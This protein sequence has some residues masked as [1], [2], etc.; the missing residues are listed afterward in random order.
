MMMN[1]AVPRLESIEQRGFLI[2]PLLL[3]RSP[4]FL[5]VSVN[6]SGMR[7]GDSHYGAVSH[8]FAECLLQRELGKC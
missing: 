3:K 4:G 5:K 1:F 7:D 6:D 8:S 2:K